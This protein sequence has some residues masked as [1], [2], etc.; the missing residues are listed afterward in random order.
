[1]P[2]SFMTRHFLTRSTQLGG[3]LKVGLPDGPG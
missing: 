1:M 3:Q 2:M